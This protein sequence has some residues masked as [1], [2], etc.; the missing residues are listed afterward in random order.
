MSSSPDDDM[1]P[2]GDLLWE[3]D[4]EE[5]RAAILLAK[6]GGN[7]RSSGP[8]DFVDAATLLSQDYG[9]T[10]WL[11]DGLITEEAVTVI[12]GEPKTAKTWA[13]IELALS[14]CTGTPAFGE[15]RPRQQGGAFLF[16]VEDNARSV[17][18]RIRSMVKGRG[19]VPDG[20]DRKLFVKPMGAMRLDDDDHLARYVATVR[21]SGIKP[22]II[23]FDPL[24]DLHHSNEDS[25]GEMQ[26]IY[27]A[28]RALRDVLRCAVVFVHHA[29]K[30]TADSANR[31]GGQRLRG[32]SALHGA[33]DAGLYMMD[34]T[35]DLEE[36]GPAKYGAL[37]ES[38]V[39]AAKSAGHFHLS[40]EVF[41][42]AQGDAVRAQW[43]HTRADNAQ[44]AKVKAQV[45]T[46]REKIIG[47]L[48]RKAIR[49]PGVPVAMREIKAE[50]A[51]G[52]RDHKLLSECLSALV[53]ERVVVASVG[54]RGAAA[55]ALPSIQAPAPAG[56]TEPWEDGPP[57]DFDW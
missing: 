39:K 2:L 49:F 28:L 42:N 18:K 55:Y 35:R 11:V 10:P 25:S 26:P 50:L 7:V 38:E 15:F 3:R 8:I 37:I 24:R 46:L 33:I 54:A 21:R 27:A 36:R 12:G 34:P 6:T 19:A 44:G 51:L 22:S 9:D 17:Q 4:L 13:A 23:V 20:W 40:L 31:R 16:L 52:G 1:V 29:G 5:A 43:V 47:A 45:G 14:I 30:A 48:E 56:D 32:S 57:D 41:D 53:A